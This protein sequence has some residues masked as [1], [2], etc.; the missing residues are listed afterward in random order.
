METMFEND[1]VRV[2]RAILVR[3]QRAPAYS[4]AAKQMVRIRLAPGALHGAVSFSDK[5]SPEKA[6][7]R[8]TKTST[9]SGWS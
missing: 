1:Y 7:G 5:G 8:S 9:R 6:N 4:P 2:V 3:G